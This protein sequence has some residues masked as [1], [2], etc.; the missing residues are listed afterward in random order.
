MNRYYGYSRWTAI[1]AAGV[2]L[3]AALGFAPAV[4]AQSNCGAT[5]TIQPGDTLFGIANFCGV[6]LSDLEQANPQITNPNL[7][8]AGNLI[9]IPTGNIIPVTGQSAQL[10]LS[11]ISGAPS[12]LVTLTGSAFPASTLVTLTGG[13]QGAAPSMSVAII[14]DAVGNFTAQMSIPVDAAQG[15]TWVFTGTSQASGNPSAAAQFQVMATPPAGLYTLQTGDTMIDLALRFNTSLFALL[16]ANPQI[17]NPNQIAV[18][19]QIF[20]PGSLVTVSGQ[21][22]YIV[23]SGDTLGVIAVNQG[24][25]LAALEAAN[26]QFT[27]PG[28]IFPGDHVTIP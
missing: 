25:T 2:V 5:A 24:T 6:T 21:N 4:A 22:V 14:A 28:L 27:N 7:I 20:I 23:K 18:G 17:L 11:P 9:N 15:T 3:V 8:F 1:L 19:Q 10:A 12:T 26:P 13:V 16:R